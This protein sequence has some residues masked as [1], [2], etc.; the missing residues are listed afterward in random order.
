MIQTSKSPRCNVPRDNSVGGLCGNHFINE[1]DYLG[2]SRRIVELSSLAAI[3]CL[4]IALAILICCMPTAL[5]QQ[6]ADI[7]FRFPNPRPAYAAGQGPRIC[8]DAGHN[9]YHVERYKPFANL[10]SSDGFRVREISQKFNADALAAC[11]LLVTVGPL[12][13]RNRGDWSFPHVPAFTR[14]ELETLIDWIRS[15]G[16]LLF[17]GDHS[18]F[19]AAA[20]DLGTMLGV[21][22]ADGTARLRS[23][24]GPDVFT[25]AD[26]N[27][28]DH[29][30]LLGRTESERI[31][32]VV[33][34]VGMAFRPS[35]E[36]SSLLQFGA[37]SFVLVNLDQNFLD[38]PRDQWPA[39]S[40]TGWSHAAAR[41]L[42]SGRVVWLGEFTICT[43]LR[44]GQERVPLG[45][46]H[47]AATQNAQFC[48][49]IV[50]WLSGILGD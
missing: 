43:A 46:N 14:D 16:G 40:I 45:M 5:A 20:S 35:R 24:P 25:R 8:I 10:L 44:A 31:D 34:V 29:P 48:L 27:F 7:E 42:G 30:I 17:I 38:L 2:L 26:G 18:P 12:G 22:M 32:T 23:G 11:D 4:C 39:F 15:G 50:R 47:P 33:S 1:L 21:V 41:K 19:P 6:V 37:E 13:D 28:L 3:P 36:W 49:N 9:N